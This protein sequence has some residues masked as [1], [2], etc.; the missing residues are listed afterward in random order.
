MKK[1]FLVIINSQYYPR[2]GTSDWYG[3][4]ETKE[5]AQDLVNQFKN[6]ESRFCEIVNLS[7]WID[8]PS[9]CWQTS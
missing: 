9:A 6:D 2:A 3:T 7:D 5:E 4:F 8:P 1:L